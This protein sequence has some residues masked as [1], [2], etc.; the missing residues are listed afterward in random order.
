[1]HGM[2]PLE[3]KYH[4]KDI[5]RSF[6]ACRTSAQIAVDRPLPRFGWVKALTRWFTRPSAVVL[7]RP[8]A[9]GATEHPAG[10]SV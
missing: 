2:T 4:L 5:E 6:N 8:V 10:S 3:V 9:T 7:N 1:M